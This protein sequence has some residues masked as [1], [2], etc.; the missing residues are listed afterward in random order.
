MFNIPE[1]IQYI[2]NYFADFV[3]DSAIVQE[4]TSA[5][6][7][8]IFIMKIRKLRKDLSQATSPAER[9]RVLRKHGP[10]L[11]VATARAFYKLYTG[12]IG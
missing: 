7:I 1:K 8:G 4:T 6:T 5:F 9:L 10:W 3:I 12:L 11:A 2:K